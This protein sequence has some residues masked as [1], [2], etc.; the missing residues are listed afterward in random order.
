MGILIIN[1]LFLTLIIL[2]RRD[3]FLIEP[4]AFPGH[5]HLRHTVRVAYNKQQRLSSL[6]TMPK[7]ETEKK[8]VWRCSSLMNAKQKEDGNDTAALP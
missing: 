8:R 4:H 5:R 1:Y 3:N 7:Q 6:S 2:R